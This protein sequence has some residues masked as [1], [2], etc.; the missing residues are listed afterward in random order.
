MPLYKS[1]VFFFL[2]FVSH[3]VI[4]FQMFSLF[5]PEMS[6]SFMS[7]IVQIIYVTLEPVTTTV[8]PAS[9]DLKVVNILNQTIV[10]AAFI[11]T[12]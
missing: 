7:Y 10:W 5:A 2:R 8:H 6:A 1:L 4:Y 3:S 12:A 9:F 11:H